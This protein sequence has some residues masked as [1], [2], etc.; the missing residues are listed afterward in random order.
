MMRRER[1]AK[2]RREQWIED[3]VKP[4]YDSDGNS[5]DS[6]GEVWYERTSTSG[7]DEWTD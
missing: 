4:G 2:S 1:P 3:D 7:D 5:I 6:N